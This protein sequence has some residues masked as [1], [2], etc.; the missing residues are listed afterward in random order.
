MT[1]SLPYMYCTSQDGSF[2]THS[3]MYWVQ[4][5]GPYMS[6]IGQNGYIGQFAQTP[7]WLNMGNMD[8]KRLVLTSTIYLGTK[9]IIIIDFAF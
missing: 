7:I 2:N 6:E 3:V 8:N 5:G 4:L 1:I 9:K